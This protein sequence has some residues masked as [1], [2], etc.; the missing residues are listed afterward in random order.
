MTDVLPA[1]GTHSPMT[2]EQI[3]E[4]FGDM[5]QDLFRVHDWR[6]GVT[7]VGE[8]P[9]EYVVTLIASN[10]TSAGLLSVSVC[11]I[12][13]MTRLRTFVGNHGSSDTRRADESTCRSAQG[14]QSGC[15][16]NSEGMST[17]AV[18]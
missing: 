5:P 3:S 10:E 13:L 18:S 16:G 12:A 11:A 15:A 4:M 8:V 6:Q 1:L 7:T 14:I 2:G 17:P 9:G